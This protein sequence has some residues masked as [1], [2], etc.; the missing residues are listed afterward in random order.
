MYLGQVIGTVVATRKLPGLEGQKL[1]LVQPLNE[2][3]QPDGAKEVA[4]PQGPDLV[5]CN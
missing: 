5:E 3:R 1:L 4:A 2:D